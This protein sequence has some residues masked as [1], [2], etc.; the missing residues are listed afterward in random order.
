MSKVRFKESTG[1]EKKEKQLFPCV[2]FWVLTETDRQEFLIRHHKWYIIFWCII[3]CA[4]SPIW[5]SPPLKPSAYTW[6]AVTGFN[7][8]GGFNTAPPPL[9][10]QQFHRRNNHR[11]YRSRN[12]S[13]RSSPPVNLHPLAKKGISG[14][15]QFRGMWSW[16]R[17]SFW[18]EG[19]ITVVTVFLLFMK[20]CV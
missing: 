5:A 7:W 11:H 20:I 14:S 2:P 3:M 1:K 8:G 10:L 19:N 13:V 9:G 4:P 6:D 15:F 18:C 12:D 16:W 17:F